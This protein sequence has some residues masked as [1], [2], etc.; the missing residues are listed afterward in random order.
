MYHSDNGTVVSAKQL[1]EHAQRILCHNSDCL[2]INCQKLKDYLFRISG[3]NKKN[4]LLVSLCKT[5][6]RDNNS[7]L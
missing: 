7:E 5:H 6:T 2:P 4:M 1:T 3:N